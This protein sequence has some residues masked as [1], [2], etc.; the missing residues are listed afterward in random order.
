MFCKQQTLRFSVI[1]LSYNSGATI[2]RATASVAGQSW[3]NIEHI[4]IDGGSS[5]STLAE[6]ERFRPQ[7]ATLVSE[8]DNGIYDAMNKGV[9]L[10]TGDVICFLHSDDMYTHSRVL[11]QVAGIFSVKASQNMALDAVY[12]DVGYFRATRPNRIVRHFRSDRFTP[13]NL[14]WGWMPAHTALF[15]K[16]SVFRETGP[17]DPSYQLAGDFEFIVR[18]FW[19]QNR[20][21]SYIPEILVRMQTGGAS[22][23]GLRSK[24]LLNREVIR[25]CRSNDVNTNYAKILSKYPFKLLELSC[26]SGP[27]N[28]FWS[29]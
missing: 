26:F 16:K 8:P 10:A 25:A 14:A 3:Q 6:L 7:I 13:E 21:T 19:G 12:G 29:N 24:I 23:S 9:A 18:A 20:L 5:D 22:T 11:E 17:F 4:I 2:A 1:T 15:L 27:K 28:G